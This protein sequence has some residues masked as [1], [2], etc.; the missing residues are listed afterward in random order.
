MSADT[1]LIGYTGV[2]LPLLGTT[3]VLFDTTVAFPA[4]GFMAMNQ[5]K[6]LEVDLFVDQI[7]TLSWQKSNNRGTTW[8]QLSTQ[9]VAIG[10]NNLDLLVEE[11]QDFRLQFVCGGTNEGVFSL[12]MAL[13]GE[14]VKSV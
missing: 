7:G 14:R 4:A 3:V 6:R 12:N 1:T 9:A 10:A 8:T 11:Y 13:S 5:M 2:A